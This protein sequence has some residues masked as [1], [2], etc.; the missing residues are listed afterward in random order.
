MIQKFVYALAAYA[1]LYTAYIQL[2]PK[3][4]IEANPNSI[5]AI[6]VN[7]PVQ[8]AAVMKDA[9]SYTADKVDIFNSLN[10]EQRRNYRGGF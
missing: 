7:D 1:A 6:K 9:A 10:A 4:F 2:R 5:A 8:Y 3:T